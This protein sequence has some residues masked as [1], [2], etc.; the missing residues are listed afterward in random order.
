[1]SYPI[2]LD[3][4]ANNSILRTTAFDTIALICIAFLPNS[5]TSKDV[6]HLCICGHCLIDY[7]SCSL[8]SLHKLRTQTLK[9]IFFI[10]RWKLKAK[11]R[12]TK[13]RCFRCFYFSKYLLCSAARWVIPESVWFIKVRDSLESAVEMINDYKN[14]ITPGLCYI[15]GRFKKLDVLAKGFLYKLRKK[16]SFWRNM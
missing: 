6:S 8:F 12:M 9:R 4:E 5:T 10:L 1:M 13:V 14:V 11:V 16:H 2:A 3:A 7:G 15:E